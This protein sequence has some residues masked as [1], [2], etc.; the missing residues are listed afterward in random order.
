MCKHP[1]NCAL[2]GK[3][4]RPTHAL[5]V[6]LINLFRACSFPFSPMKASASS[7]LNPMTSPH[8][9]LVKDIFE[10]KNALAEKKKTKNKDIQKKKH[11]IAKMRL[12]VLNV[13]CMFH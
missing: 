1:D 7:T 6:L 5:P 9:H 11:H 8:L 13:Q 3:V 10:I 2:P 12:V 4:S